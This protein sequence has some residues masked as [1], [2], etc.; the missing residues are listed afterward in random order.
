MEIHQSQLNMILRCGEQFRRRYVLGHII[1]PSIAA[2][3]GT[4]VHYANELN[5]RHK[6][7]YEYDMPADDLMDAA[8]DKYVDV[9]SNGVYLPKEE[10][11]AKKRLL[12]EGLD[13]TVRLTKLY[14]EAVAPILKPAEPEAQFKVTVPGTDLTIAGTMDLQADNRVDDL[15]TSTRSWPK[16]RIFKE[17]QPVLYS[18]A[19][20]LLTGRK[21]EFHYHVLV[22][23]TSGEKHQALSL[24]ADQ[25]MY[26]A[27][28]EKLKIAY[29]SVK[30]GIFLPANPTSWW[31][32][33]TSS[34]AGSR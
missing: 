32:S 10:H 11:S 28:I 29:Q 6:I 1:P 20:E 30:A 3:R 2:A 27:L 18:L 22:A 31:C 14:R 23:L 5:I 34:A 4:G 17:I 16:D 21:P 12:G 8:R 9:L 33:P 19:H 7:I 24:R 25:R 15:K 13:Q 26:K